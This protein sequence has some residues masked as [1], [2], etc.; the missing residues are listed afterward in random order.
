MYV[1]IFDVETMYF[2]DFLYSSFAGLLDPLCV[3][4]KP[5]DFLHVKEIRMNKMELSNNDRWIDRFNV[6]IEEKKRFVL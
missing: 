6:G 1:C 5:N 2:F 3:V 4:G